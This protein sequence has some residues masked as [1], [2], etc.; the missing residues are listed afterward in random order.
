MG[1]NTSPSYSIMSVMLSQQ[2]CLYLTWFEASCQFDISGQ[3]LL[4]WL[5]SEIDAVHL[6]VESRRLVTQLDG[7]LW[8]SGDDPKH[9]KTNISNCWQQCRIREVMCLNQ[10]SHGTVL[11]DQAVPVH[12]WLC[13]HASPPAAWGPAGLQGLMGRSC[14]STCP[15]PA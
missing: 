9:T 8:D 6:I 15:S 12:I 4:L 2:I 3:A 14:I 7:D 5:D 11:H 13:L 1:N 10:A